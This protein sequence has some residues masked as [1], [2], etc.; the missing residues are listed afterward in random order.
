MYTPS[1]LRYYLPPAFSS[2]LLSYTPPFPPGCHPQ[3]PS[4]I[5]SLSVSRS[6]PLLCDDETHD[7]TDAQS[8]LQR[9]SVPPIEEVV[10]REGGAKGTC[11]F[12]IR[13]V[14]LKSISIMDT[15]HM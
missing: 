4:T 7:Q 3:W 5:A 9:L 15:L 1:R 8:V 13:F 14:H 2:S 12:I 6:S 10:W 11:T